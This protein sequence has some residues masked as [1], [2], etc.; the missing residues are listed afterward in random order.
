[1][2]SEQNK[3]TETENK[4]NNDG[5]N[6]KG[7]ESRA[8]VKEFADGFYSEMEKSNSSDSPILET[9]DLVSKYLDV[10]TFTMIYN[11]QTFGSLKEWLGFRNMFTPN[12]SGMEANI[13]IE[14]W[15]SHS[16]VTSFGNYVKF[17][18]GQAVLMRGF[19]THIMSS[20]C[21]KISTLIEVPYKDCDEKMTKVVISIMS[22]NKQ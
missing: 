21:K 4:S 3:S 7:F 1:M 9:D 10:D 11:N 17:K 20:K 6:W 13:K 19:A 22:T 15:C 5:N 14:S 8:D 12:S 18:N 16:F 2:A